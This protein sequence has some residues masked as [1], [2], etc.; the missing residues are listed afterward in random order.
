M[1][2]SLALGFLSFTLFAIL[3]LWARTR[4][5]LA[6]ARLARVEEDAIDLGLDPRYEA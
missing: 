2:L 4:L 1:K 5:E 6:N 3:L